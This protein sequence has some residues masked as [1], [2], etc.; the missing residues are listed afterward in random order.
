MLFCLLVPTSLQSIQ[1][2]L[3]SM[4][5]YT[6]FDIVLLN[7]STKDVILYIYWQLS[8]VNQIYRVIFWST[9]LGIL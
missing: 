4:V 1:V 2:S 9:V 7:F 3:T 8:S 5:Y 6:N